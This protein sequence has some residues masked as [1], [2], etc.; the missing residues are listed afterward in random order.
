M[1]TTRREF[2][3]RA[4]GATG[5]VGVIMAA[6]SAAQ[7]CMYGQ[8]AVM[9]PN[10]HVDMVDEGTCQHKCERCGV[11]AFSDNVVTV[12]CRNGHPNRITTGAAN[13]EQITQHYLCSVCKTDCR[14]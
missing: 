14:L 2:M 1:N 13:R 12:V 8:W 3:A 10:G 5:A 9:C 4:V 6:P 11:Q 7:A